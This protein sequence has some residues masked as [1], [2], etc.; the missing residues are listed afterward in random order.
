MCRDRK[1]ITAQWVRNR[2][3][4]QTSLEVACLLLTLSTKPTGALAGACLEAEHPRA[5]ILLWA[6]LVNAGK[7]VQSDFNF[8]L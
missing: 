5:S 2:G 4:W 1:Q 6:P 8:E 3:N 7:D